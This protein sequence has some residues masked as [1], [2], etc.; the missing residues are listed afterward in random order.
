MCPLKGIS[1]DEVDFRRYKQYGFL[2]QD[3]LNA[4]FCGTQPTI[5][6]S[7]WRDN[8]ANTFRRNTWL[9]L[10]PWYWQEG[11]GKGMQSPPWFSLFHEVQRETKSEDE[12]T[13][14]RALQ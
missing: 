2:K 1:E 12:I 11:G 7:E 4:I 10:N 8:Y 13:A 5:A 3:Q 14:R 6:H 9:F